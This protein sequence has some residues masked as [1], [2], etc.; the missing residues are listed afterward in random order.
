RDIL[1]RRLE[2][3]LAER[4]GQLEVQHAAWLAALGAGR[5]PHLAVTETLAALDA[6]G[7][8]IARENPLDWLVE[9]NVERDADGVGVLAGVK[10]ASHQWH[11]RLLGHDEA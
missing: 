6:P 7:Q 10:E 9:A 5:R 4:R 3:R 8:Q 11:D 2:V 1:D